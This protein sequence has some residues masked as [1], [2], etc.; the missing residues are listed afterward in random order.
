M[1][2]FGNIAKKPATFKVFDL[3]QIV[4][5]LNSHYS[6]ITL[7]NRASRQCSRINKLPNHSLDMGSRIEASC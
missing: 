1:E 3:D 6:I 2:P 4:T 5:N 7:M